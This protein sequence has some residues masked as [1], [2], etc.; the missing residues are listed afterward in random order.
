MNLQKMKDLMTALNKAKVS[1]LFHDVLI[2]NGEGDQ[3]VDRDTFLDKIK[4]DMLYSEN[5]A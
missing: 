2:P 1:D 3:M 5:E 4:A